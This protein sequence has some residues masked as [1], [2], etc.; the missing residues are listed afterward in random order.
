M[1]TRFHALRLFGL[2][3]LVLAACNAPLQ[4]TPTATQVV[5]LTPAVALTPTLT[6][7]PPSA[8]VL[9]TP[10]PGPT[11]TPLPFLPTNLAVIDA[12]NA[13]DLQLVAE[14]R[15][16][17]GN[18]S[19][20]IFSP[21]GQTLVIR[22]SLTNNRHI[23]EVW[24]L[25]TGQLRYTLGPWG[26]NPGNFPNEMLFSP[27]SKSL[28]LV[29]DTSLTVL[30]AATGQEQR[31]QNLGEYLNAEENESV[32]ALA[33]N[34]Q[35]FVA[36]SYQSSSPSM[37][38]RWIDLNNGTELGAVTIYNDNNG[39]AQAYISPDSRTL[40]AI[41]HTSAST[42]PVNEIM[43]AWDTV[44][45]K[46]L[47]TRTGAFNEFNFAAFSPDSQQIAIRQSDAQEVFLL[48]ASDGK[49]RFTLKTGDN[50]KPHHVT[51]SLDGSVVALQTSYQQ[52]QLWDATTGK[53]LR[54]LEDVSNNVVFAPNGR[55]LLSLGVHD[56]SLTVWL[57]GYAP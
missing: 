20:A 44:S 37:R 1:K 18:A 8:T 54:I 9:P 4:P 15:R 24:D 10:T 45:G 25:T 50:Q 17:E 13:P 23:A 43:I 52:L 21:D 31:T 47:W 53:Q 30:E 39:S 2:F 36:S 34:W 32:L 27:D 28:G 48:N 55:F 40:V 49:T 51:F 5:Q 6:A 7:I 3:G 12:S 38:L 11:P 56:P 29:S 22:V 57:W 42:P 16:S 41:Y 33:P 46:R 14:I 19:N 26:P 35:F